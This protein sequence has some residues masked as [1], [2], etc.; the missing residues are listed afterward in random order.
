VDNTEPVASAIVAAG[1][2][3]RRHVD[4]MTHVALVRRD[5]HTRDEWTLP[6]G[7]LAE[8]DDTLPEA[9]RR[10]VREEL[11]VTVTLGD[12]A[13]VIDYPVGDGLKVVVFW[14]MTY[15]GE[16]SGE[17]DAGEVREVRWL[18]LHEA[19][20]ML[21]HP[22]ERALLEAVASSGR[23][24][25]RPGRQWRPVV[26]T[27]LRRP[28]LSRL[29]DEIADLTATLAVASPEGA[30]SQ[31]WRWAALRHVA[32]AREA[33]S[34]G[35]IDAGWNQAYRARECL[36]EGYDAD[37][38]LRG[39]GTL[40]D[41][42]VASGKF[43]QWRRL[44]AVNLLAPVLD[45]TGTSDAGSEE[46][47]RAR[48]REALRIRNESFDNDYRKL[49]ILRRHQRSLL[50]IGSA[51]MLVLLPL[52][53]ANASSL[54]T[55][56][57]DRAWVMFAAALLGV[58]GAVTSAAQRSSRISDERIPRQL[59]SH[60]AS[61]S[62]IPIGAVAGLLVWLAGNTGLAPSTGTAAS[63]LVGAFAAGF[64]ERVVAVP[65]SNSSEK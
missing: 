26:R 56:G 11:G 3:V 4:G 63:V 50:G 24:Q 31:P 13:G 42:L 32:Q 48:L 14:L 51:S 25:M 6:K 17:R 12:V 21:E 40:R 47:R 15:A 61:T 57:V 34:C 46:G 33:V 28:Q 10:E 55:G 30:D 41:E 5:R 52:L 23:L 16:A 20:R 35:D 37:E 29:L 8:Q 65:P 9:A 2:I 38:V 36:I 22:K 43:S 62:R 39:A 59:G 27:W 54:D 60:V 49:T 64:T 18:P 1:G 58:V 45:A 44:A 53:A 7:K 19:T